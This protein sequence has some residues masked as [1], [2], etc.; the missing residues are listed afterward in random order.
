[1][2]RIKM[3]EIW[4]GARIE[5]CKDKKILMMAPRH[6]LVYLSI[7][8]F[9]HSFTNISLLHDVEKAAEFYKDE[10]G[11]HKVI[12]VAKDWG[13]DLP[14][15]Y[16]LYFTS[17]I[18]DRKLAGDVLKGLKPKRISK[19]DERIISSI[20]KNKGGS[21]NL[22]YPLY[23]SMVKSFFKKAKFFILSLFPPPKQVIQ[24]YSIKHKYLI[25]FYY[26]KRLGWAVNQV[27]G[28]IGRK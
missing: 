4:Q 20:L 7:H 8:A 11:W 27:I 10:L 24:I 13:A 17:E 22:V 25:L 16:A 23:L 5:N 28:F 15:Y 12:N 14:L 6:L 26:F 19:L 18:L 2:Y 1:M 21:H 9:N 3:E